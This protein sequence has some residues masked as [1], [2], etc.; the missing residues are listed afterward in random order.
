VP[1]A[2]AI[3]IAIATAIATLAVDAVDDQLHRRHT[4]MDNDLKVCS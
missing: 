3:A 4:V 1:V 2:I